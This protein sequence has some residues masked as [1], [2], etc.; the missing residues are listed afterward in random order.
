TATASPARRSV[1]ATASR[2]SGWCDPRVVVLLRLPGSE[3][4]ADLLR[5]LRRVAC[6]LEGLTAEDTSRVVMEP[7][8]I[9]DRTLGQHH[10]RPRRPDQP[11]VVAKDLVVSPF[12]QRFL[13]AEREPEIHGAGEILLGGVE[14]ME[15]RKLFGT[16]HGKRV[17]NLGAD[18]VLPAIAPR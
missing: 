18:L 3:A 15:R 12:F 1:S 6:S 9:G 17:E 8:S 7:S 5:I 2:V 13:D 14:T 4:F 16:E 11:H 10:I